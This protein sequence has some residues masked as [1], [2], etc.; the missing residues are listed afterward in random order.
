MHSNLQSL[1]SSSG[2]RVSHR[3]AAFALQLKSRNSGF[4]LADNRPIQ[5]KENKTG[6]PDQ[7]KSGIENLSGHSMNDV[8]VHYNSSQPA[9]LNAH[10]YAQGNQIHIAPGQEKHLSHEAWHVVQQKQGRVQPT[11]QMKG[12][13][14]IND[15]ASL[16]KEADVMGAKALQF[17]KYS[18]HAPL[19]QF[20]IN[21]D[22]L[23]L[24]I[25][26]TKG[27]SKTGAAPAAKAF[28]AG[29][30]NALT[31]SPK[32]ANVVVK[33]SGATSSPA[34]L[35]GMGTWRLKL[36]LQDPSKGNAQVLTRMHAIRGK[37]GGP[38]DAENMFL[39]T[40]LSN[41]FNPNSH[42]SQVESPIQSFLDTKNSI[43]VDYTVVPHYTGP[44]KYIQDRIHGI[45]DKTTKTAF[46]NWANEALPPTFTCD[47]KMYRNNAGVTE[48]S[49][50]SETLSAEIGS[51][52][53]TVMGATGLATAAATGVLAGSALATA[54]TVA[55][56]YAAGALAS[57]GM[58]AAGG[59]AATLTV[60][61]AP[62]IAAG[63]GIAAAGYGAMALGG[64][65][66]RDNRPKAGAYKFR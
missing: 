46:A 45:T 11:M 8:K 38:S 51:G 58:I 49:H 65:F 26:P 24:K 29:G 54:G 19:R 5:R 48:M 22:L 33:K 59:T 4:C 27:F 30:T 6:L 7:L 64:Y 47:V 32:G 53:A 18:S 44:P 39:G 9:Q 2:E 52:S 66:L 20:K 36:L 61:A 10:A 23:Q 40:A 31:S 16:E 60:A 14:N 50:Q 56:T 63:A 25:D 28:T 62:F 57:A 35:N 34:D 21:P 15:D 55:G 42:Y 17:A 1:P 12:K 43:A 3:P 13:V 37:F 41:N